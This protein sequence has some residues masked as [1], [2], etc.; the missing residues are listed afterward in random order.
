M[1]QDEMQSNTR[2]AHMMQVVGIFFRL[3]FLHRL[4]SDHGFKEQMDDSLTLHQALLSFLRSPATHLDSHPRALQLILNEMTTGDQEADALLE[5][6]QEMNK[7]VYLVH[8]A[9]WQQSERKG[10]WK[11]YVLPE[12]MRE[13]KRDVTNRQMYVQET[14]GDCLCTLTTR[15]ITAQYLAS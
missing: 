4:R 7:A 2:F 15:Y 9:S 10:S 1:I 13:V 11:D 14:C 12:A 8:L 3:Y 6:R 5:A